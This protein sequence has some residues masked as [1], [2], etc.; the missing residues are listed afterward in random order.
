M[1][2]QQAL[3]LLWVQETS[4]PCTSQGHSAKRPLWD[5]SIGCH[6]IV[7]TRFLFQRDS[8]GVQNFVPKGSWGECRQGLTSW[9]YEG[10]DRTKNKPFAGVPER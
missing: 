10:M 3:R 2:D 8:T 9:N 4:A 7:L 5:W 1:F 6:A